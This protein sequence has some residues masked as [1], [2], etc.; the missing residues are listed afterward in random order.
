ME[1]TQELVKEYFDYKD[2]ALYW[3][4]KTKGRI[5]FGEIAGHKQKFPG[6]SDRWVVRIKG[7]LFLLSRVIFLWHKGYM[8]ELVDHKDRNQL[9]NLID[10]LREA[11]LSQNGCNRTSRGTS[12]YLGVHLNKQGR[13]VAQIKSKNHKQN[14]GAYSTEEEA[15]LAYNTVVLKCHGEF[16]NLNIIK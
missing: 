10:N 15:A 16:A 3:K 7:S 1:L 14:L 13:W 8:P 9:N 5:F 4:L 6:K 11:D 12:K 2:G